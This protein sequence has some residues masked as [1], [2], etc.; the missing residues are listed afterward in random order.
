MQ[1]KIYAKALLS[2]LQNGGDE[3]KILSELFSHLKAEG[4]MKLL[5][6]ILRE[7]RVQLARKNNLKANLEVASEGELMSAKTAAKA[8]GI[9]AEEV[10]INRGLI[11]GWRARKEGVLVDRSGKKAL[12]ELY[13][14]IITT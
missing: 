2:A 11:R 8:A 14:N 13:R 4:R 12:I 7:L 6:G 3:E 10:T 9:D 1:Q 5:P